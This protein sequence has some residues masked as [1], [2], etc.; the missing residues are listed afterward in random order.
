MPLRLCPA[1]AQAGRS[2]V[3]RPKGR[4]KFRPLRIQRATRASGWAREPSGH[5][6]SSLEA[7]GPVGP[8]A[9]RGSQRAT[10]FVFD[11]DDLGE[12]GGAALQAAGPGLQGG[13]WRSAAVWFK[14]LPIAMASLGRL[15]QPL[16]CL[17]IARRLE[18]HPL[19]VE[20]PADGFGQR[21]AR[22]CT[23]ATRASF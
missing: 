6:Y 2:P 23:K 9:Q 8:P 13:L 11:R 22:H 17:S 15:V 10:G 3:G 19:F 5:Q 1:R 12:T 14:L 4:F 21:E 18:A 16:Q 20:G 7:P